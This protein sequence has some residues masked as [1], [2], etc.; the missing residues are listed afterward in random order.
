MQQVAIYYHVLRDRLRW[1]RVPRR[2]QFKLCLLTFRAL[3]GLAPP[4]V[5]DLCRPVASVG[6]GRGLRSAAR[7]GLVVGS[8]AARFGARAF[9]V[10]G[11][12]AWSLLP[13]HLRTLETVGPFGTALETY[14][15]SIQ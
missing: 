2:V 10:A 5:A 15:H 11:P 7:G 8:S 6:G 3:R 12:G 9:A 4:C 1:L 14:L 13:A